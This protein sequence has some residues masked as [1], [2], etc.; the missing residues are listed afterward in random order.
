GRTVLLVE[1]DPRAVELFTLYLDGEGF[2]VVACTDGAD[3]IAQ[4]RRLQPAA[5]VLDIMLPH[6]SGWDF[7][8]LAKSDASTAHIPVVVVSMVDE[9]GKGFALG[10]AD[11]L[12]KPVSRDALLVA[13]QGI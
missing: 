4:A 3:A 9:R 2:D 5:I 8:T 6:L 12:V 11:Y 7:L 1:D 10:A 13:L